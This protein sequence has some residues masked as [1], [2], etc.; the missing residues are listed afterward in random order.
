M[1]AGLDRFSLPS[2]DP[3]TVI[4]PPGESRQ[5]KYFLLQRV[6]RRDRHFSRSVH[7]RHLSQEG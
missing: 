5:R 2:I 4:A 1:A 7:L 3:S 6:V